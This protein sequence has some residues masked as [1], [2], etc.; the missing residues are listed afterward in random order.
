MDCP[1]CG[2]ALY[3]RPAVDITNPSRKDLH[4]LYVC[5]AEGC[6]GGEGRPG[7]EIVD[8]EPKFVALLGVR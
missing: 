2:S 5:E 3:H 1:R 8:G 7:F 4:Y 6:G